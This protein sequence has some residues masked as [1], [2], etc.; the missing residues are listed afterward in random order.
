MHSV[1][2]CGSNERVQVK[3]SLLYELQRKPDPGQAMPDAGA[4]FAEALEQGQLADE[5]GFHTFWVTEHHFLPGFALSAA[6]D[7]VLATLAARTSKIRIGA[8]VVVLPYHHPIHVAERMG[9]LDHLSGGRLEFGTGRGGLFE[10]TGHNIA[11]ED[12]RDMWT[13]SLDL[14]VDAWGTYPDEFSWEGT[15]WTVPPRIVIPQPV[16]QPHPPLWV[17]ALQ[18]ETYQI[19]AERGIGVLA[20]VPASPSLVQPHI[21]AYHDRVESIARTGRHV[22]NKWASLAYA[23]CA[24]DNRRGREIGA[25]VIRNFFRPDKPYASALQQVSS[26]I[27]EKWG[28]EVPAHLKAHFAGLLPGATVANESGGVLGTGRVLEREDAQAVWDM[29]DANTLA[30]M[31][32]TVSGDPDSCIAALRQYQ[33]AG[34]DEVMLFV[35]SEVLNHQEIMNSLRLFGTEVLP[36]FSES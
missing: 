27:L 30:D 3:I 25:E 36:A 15:H 24:P 10:Q 4:I 16:Q 32:I 20:F 26:G 31:A 23:H 12:S 9:T 7:L 8:G 2:R 28:G 6:S 14:L 5:V 13:E 33:A 1:S 29:V 19:A 11:P 18:E 35:Q 22:N 17:A 34:A 21:A